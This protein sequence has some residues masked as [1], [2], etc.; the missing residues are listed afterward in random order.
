[1]HYDSCPLSHMRIFFYSRPTSILT[2]ENSLLDSILA[3]ADERDCCQIVV[4]GCV[5]LT[6]LRG[7]I[8]LRPRQHQLPIDGDTRHLNQ[9]IGL[10]SGTKAC[11][12]DVFVEANL[13][14]SHK[15]KN[16]FLLTLKILPPT[17][18]YL[19]HTL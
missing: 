9:F 11:G 12:A 5:M 8:S 3:F 16:T 2:R 6:R 14:V 10:P 18:G 15:C 7:G 4:N 1:M 19:H 17:F 13:I